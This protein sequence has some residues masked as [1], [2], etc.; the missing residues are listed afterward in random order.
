MQ[1]SNEGSL[2]VIQSITLRRREAGR[3]AGLGGTASMARL[4]W[5]ER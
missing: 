3:A 5:A 2:L 4:F 1:H